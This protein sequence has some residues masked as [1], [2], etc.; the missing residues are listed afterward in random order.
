[1]LT[2][3]QTNRKNRK[4]WTAWGLIL[5][6]CTPLLA[7]TLLY[8]FR[9]YFTFDHLCTGQLYTPP[10]HINSLS[11]FDKTYLGKWQMIYIRPIECDTTCQD[12]QNTLAAIYTS[13]GKER[14][15]VI[16]RDIFITPEITKSLEAANQGG[17]LIIDPQGWL[18]VHYPPHSDPK[19][20]LKD[21]RRLL[22]L[23]HV[24]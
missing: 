5:V 8:G 10:I 4:P 23:S 13:L 3:R 12:L 11:F 17:M 7:A 19:G 2:S 1:M 15:R 21:F 9:H 20:I 14:E 16:P 18:V 6:F 24:G 22:R